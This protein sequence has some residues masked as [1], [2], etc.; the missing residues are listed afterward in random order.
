[1]NNE[2]RYMIGKY[3]KT[4][5]YY[6]FLHSKSHGCLARVAE[7]FIKNHSQTT[8]N[9][10]ARILDQ[11]SFLNKQG[12]V[13]TTKLSIN[14]QVKG[15]LTL[16]YRSQ[17]LVD[18][19]D[20]VSEP[21]IY[22]F[23]AKINEQYL[24]SLKVPGPL[25]HLAIKL[26]RYFF[27][28]SEI[29][30]IS[31][32][33]LKNSCESLPYL[34]NSGTC[35]FETYVFQ[36]YGTR[37]DD[38]DDQEYEDSNEITYFNFEENKSYKLTVD[39]KHEILPRHSVT[40]CAF[41]KNNSYF[42]YVFGGQ[43]QAHTTWMNREIGCLDVIDIV[44]LYMTDDPSTGQWQY[45]MLSKS[46]LTSS[47]TLSFIP[48]KYSYAYYEDNEEK[49]ILMGGTTFQ[50]SVY[51]WTF[52][53]FEF[54]TK[55]NKFISFDT[56][57]NDAKGNLNIKRVKND[58]SKTAVPEAIA[59]PNKNFYFEKANRTFHFVVPSREDDELVCHYK[60]NRSNSTC[61]FEHSTTQ[62]EDP[63]KFKNTFNIKEVEKQEGQALSLNFQ[64]EI[65][66]CFTTLPLRTALIELIDYL[67]S[68]D[69]TTLIDKT[70][71]YNYLD[72]MIKKG[73]D[74]DGV[75]NENE[76]FE[77]VLI[78][79]KRTSAFK[80]VKRFLQRDENIEV[81]LK[82]DKQLKEVRSY[83]A[84]REQNS[85]R[86]TAPVMERSFEDIND[87]SA[88]CEISFHLHS[89]QEQD[90]DQIGISRDSDDYKET[91]SNQPNNM[92]D[93]S[94]KRQDK[95]Q[96]DITFFKRTEENKVEENILDNGFLELELTLEDTGHIQEFKKSLTTSFNYH[97]FLNIPRNEV[98]VLL[99]PNQSGDETISL[100]FKI[101]IEQ[102]LVDLSFFLSPSSIVI[103]QGVVVCYIDQEFKATHPQVYKAYK[104][105]IL[106]ANVEEA[107]TSP[108]RKSSYLV[109]KKLLPLCQED[110]IFGRCLAVNNENLY[111]FGGK[112][113]KY[114]GKTSMTYHKTL[115]IYSITKMKETL[116][117]SIELRDN[118]VDEMEYNSGE[119]V[120]VYNS[121]QIF[122]CK[123]KEPSILEVFNNNGTIQTNV[124]LD[125]S[126]KECCV[127]L[128][129]V[130]FRG[131]EEILL[132]LYN[133]NENMRF[134]LY[135]IENQTTEGSVTLIPTEGEENMLSP[136]LYSG[137]EEIQHN[138]SAQ[139]L[140][141][142]LVYNYRE[143]EP[144][145]VKYMI[146]VT[147]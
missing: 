101:V 69:V 137:F 121:K 62:S 29:E 40:A 18:Y 43:V 110:C 23:N 126:L 124:D 105:C 139:P 146:N 24:T 19:K 100:R 88:S 5:N 128:N 145:I 84:D 21:T 85:T 132:T 82:Q 141:E 98:K 127:H 80:A 49:I 15:E 38:D 30:I 77:P 103:Y 72:V 65:T 46:S 48:F 92:I 78:E 102:K 56:F 32:F 129:L 63:K 136:L 34:F 50:D 6:H 104:N 52:P 37:F 70:L 45:T 114:K 138:S 140:K 143:S 95:N 57:L 91:E 66:Y 11:I 7:H 90:N 39:K 10:K 2:C 22:I 111:L 36:V 79:S 71:I 60:Y 99:P 44:E 54:D 86:Q 25:S 119:C 94:E 67:F 122:I 1:M 87:A 51:D 35:Y 64:K 112:S 107:L 4:H 28:V 26:E 144:K 27:D 74:N 12:D 9:Y 31:R 59:S 33:P 20:G 147:K 109:F 123:R 73:L 81:F 61:S 120:M 134:L 96:K 117:S 108:D 125:I 8:L 118:E 97:A 113:I 68:I 131:K 76:T 116:S 133:I 41:K 106:F 14:G 53:V 3:Y 17:Y 83:L 55:M 58:G 47:K 142:I 75:F 115:S 130:N 89:D 93:F 135:D 42:L 16:D 13:T